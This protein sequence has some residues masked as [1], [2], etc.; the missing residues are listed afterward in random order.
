MSQESLEVDDVPAHL[1]RTG[2]RVF[3]AGM[4]GDLESG[5]E[6]SRNLE[7]RLRATASV[8]IMGAYDLRG[9]ASLP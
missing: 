7:Q 6:G 1:I 8:S 3:D 9:S 2:V 5:Q 4:E